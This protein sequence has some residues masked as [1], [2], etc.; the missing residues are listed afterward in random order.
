MM[1]RQFE[2]KYIEVTINV[3]NTQEYE[4]WPVLT[5]HVPFCSGFGLNEINIF[6]DKDSKT[7]STVGVSFNF[8]SF[9]FKLNGFE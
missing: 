3:M 9:T 7:C 6:F 8:L 2:V 1:A 4:H 5:P